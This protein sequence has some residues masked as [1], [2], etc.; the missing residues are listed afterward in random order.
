MR[1]LKAHYTNTPEKIYGNVIND[2]V[3]ETLPRNACVEVP[4]LVDGN[5]FSKCYVGKLPEQ[6]AALNRSNIGCQLMTIEAAK[7]R[8]KED[9]YMAAYLDPHTAAELSMDDVKSLCDDLLDAH[10]DFMPE[11]K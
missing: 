1:I 2:G 9:L 5:G 3:I 10:K 8:K 6:L 11:Y 4:V 7:S